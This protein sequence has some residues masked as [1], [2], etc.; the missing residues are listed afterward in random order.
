M[1]FWD[2]TCNNCKRQTVSPLTLKCK[3]CGFDLNAPDFHSTR[4]GF[5]NEI[6]R[7]WLEREKKRSQGD[8]DQND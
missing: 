6:A 8:T 5:S 2:F 4:H 3:H 7:D 1:A